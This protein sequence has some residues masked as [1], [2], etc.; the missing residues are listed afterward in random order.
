[1]NKHR[2]SVFLLTSLFGILSEYACIRLYIKWY[3]GDLVKVSVLNLFITF[4]HIL[5]CED[6]LNSDFQKILKHPLLKFLSFIASFFITGYAYDLIKGVH[7]LPE[8]KSDCLTFL[9]FLCMLPPLWMFY[10][11]I[12]D[13]E[14]DNINNEDS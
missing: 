9:Y 2:N 10:N 14:N 5:V 3:T 1:M 11:L 4:F 13:Y 6:L 7:E 12:F 8:N